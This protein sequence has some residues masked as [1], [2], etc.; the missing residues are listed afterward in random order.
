VIFG[1]QLTQR[2]VAQVLTTWDS[3]AIA[4]QWLLVAVATAGAVQ[5]ASSLGWVLQ[6]ISF[7]HKP[8]RNRVSITSLILAVVAVALSYFCVRHG[9][10][11]TWSDGTWQK[12]GIVLAGLAPVL[13]FVY[14]RLWVGNRSRCPRRPSRSSP[15][16]A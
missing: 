6:L 3:P 10:W 11:P 13:A 9:F 4:P 16:R 12:V 1:Y 8:I 14:L 2:S 7:L 5:V 15:S